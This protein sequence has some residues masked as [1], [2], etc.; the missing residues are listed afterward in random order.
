VIDQADQ[1]GSRVYMQGTNVMQATTYGLNVDQLDYAHV[2]AQ[3]LGFPYHSGTA[4]NVFGG[5]Q[6]AAGDPQG[7]QT[8]I[9][10]GAAAVN[11]LTFNVARG[12][13]LVAEDIWYE[14]DCSNMPGFLTGSGHSNISLQAVSISL[15]SGFA[16]PAILL[17]NFTGTAT[18]DGLLIQDRIIVSGNS[19]GA[20]VLVTGSD[21]T[22]THMNPF[23]FNQSMAANNVV[24][25]N[26]AFA[27][28]NRA[29]VGAVNLGTA[30]RAFILSMFANLRAAHALTT[31]TSTG[32]GVTDARIFNV[33]IN[34]FDVDMHIEAGSAP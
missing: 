30:S 1:P 31:L 9:F 3:Q 14:C 20:D 28:P 8:L 19:G 33:S 10:A 34:L 23:V 11:N 18:F 13:T 24:A 5:P 4:I 27:P 16:Q 32:S 21:E 7:G 25:V 26:N 2:E 29:A 17:N 15:P 22:T 12:G 6:A